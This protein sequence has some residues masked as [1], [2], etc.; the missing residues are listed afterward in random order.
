MKIKNAV[1]YRYGIF[2]IKTSIYKETEQNKLPPYNQR[3][4]NTV[5]FTFFLL[6]LQHSI[7]GMVRNKNKV[8]II[9]WLL[10]LTLLPVNIVKALHFHDTDNVTGTHV[11]TPYSYNTDSCCICQFILSPCTEAGHAAFS[12]T[13]LSVPLGQAW[14]PEINANAHTCH[15]TTRAPPFHS[16]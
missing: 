1:L 10:V 8:R 12:F 6:T 7:T 4:K 15:I 16:V 9:A 13:V 5:E 14:Y 3:R 2:C 11:K